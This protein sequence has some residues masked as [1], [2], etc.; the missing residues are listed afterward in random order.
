MP[1]FH[2]RPL[3]QPCGLPFG[4]CELGLANGPLPF[5]VFFPGPGIGPGIGDGT[6]VADSSADDRLGSMGRSLGRDVVDL[7]LSHHG[8]RF[9]DSD[10]DYPLPLDIH[11]EDV[12]SLDSDVDG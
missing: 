1:I 11:A 6:D 12:P 10:V 5:G 8:K 2:P 4:T 7:G 3:R 9:R